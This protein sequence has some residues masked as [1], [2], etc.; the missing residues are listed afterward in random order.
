M[1]PI[2]LNIPQEPTKLDLVKETCEEILREGI[3]DS[4][5]F[6][7]GRP[8][9]RPS[10]MGEEYDAGFAQGRKEAARVIL[11]TL[12]YSSVGPTSDNPDEEIG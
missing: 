6:N 5:A 10:F 9:K 4:R 8:V 3:A 7:E 11:I 12:G 2:K 1:E